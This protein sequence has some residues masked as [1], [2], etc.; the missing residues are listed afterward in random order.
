M[1]A[2]NSRRYPALPDAFNNDR[3][4]KGLQGCVSEEYTV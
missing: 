4:T 2:V 1:T 3:I